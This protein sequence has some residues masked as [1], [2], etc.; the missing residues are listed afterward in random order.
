MPLSRVRGNNGALLHEIVHIYAPNDNRFLAEG[1]AVY[2]QERMGGN[3]GFPNW[4]G[5]DFRVLVRDILSE[6]SSLKMLNEV[7]TPTPL[8]SVAENRTAYILAGSFVG[9]LI[10][11]YGLPKFKSLYQ[12]ESYNKVYGKSLR[13]LEKEWR[14]SF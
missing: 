1:F 8:S 6:V 11:K 5:E 2:L 10:E 14:S 4:R 12:T 7:Q 13:S 9:F 3:S